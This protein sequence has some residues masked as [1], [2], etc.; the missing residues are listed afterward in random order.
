MAAA[1]VNPPA[2]ASGRRSMP[3][4]SLPVVAFGVSLSAFFVISYLLCVLGF[5]LER[6]LD[7]SLPIAH[8]ALS[9]LLP[10][11]AFDSWS[12]FFL[13]LAESVA[14]GWYVALIFG[15]LYNHVAARIHGERP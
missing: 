9:V 3:A 11:F 12:R 15:P 5:Y 14:W 13:G 7:W 8:G 4:H 10:G 2:A 6:S 1:S